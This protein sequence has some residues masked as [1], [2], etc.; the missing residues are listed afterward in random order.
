MD[1]SLPGSSVCVS[2]ARILVWVV[3]SFSKRSLQPRNWTCISCIIGSF[4]LFFFF[5]KTTEQPGKPFLFLLCF[6]YFSFISFYPHCYGNVCSFDS[7]HWMDFIAR[8]QQFY[9]S[10]LPRI[11]TQ[12]AREVSEGEKALAR[13]IS[14]GLTATIPFF[15]LPRLWRATTCV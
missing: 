5:L 14:D 6:S 15:I 9:V 10:L 4:V 8:V 2:Q 7:N 11:N 13:S 12:V 1:Y 3:I